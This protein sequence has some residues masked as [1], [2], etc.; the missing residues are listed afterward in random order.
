MIMHD[1][2]RSHVDHKSRMILRRARQRSRKVGFTP[3]QPNKFDTSVA[4][5]I[6]V[7][8]ENYEKDG[9]K[10]NDGEIIAEARSAVR[11]TLPKPT[12]GVR[13]KPYGSRSK[14]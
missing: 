10:R 13:I 4:A 12:L 5:L 8:R 7:L 6:K 3:T 11:A 14:Y 1:D 9:I 2:R